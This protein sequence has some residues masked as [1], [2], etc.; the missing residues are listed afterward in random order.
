MEKKKSTVEGKRAKYGYMF[1]AP[2][3]IV[4]VVFSIY[5][6]LYTLYLSFTRFD[7]FVDPVWIGFDNYRRVLFD[8]PMFWKSLVNTIRI[9]GI[10]I[11]VQVGLAF[12]LIMV[13]SDLKYKIKG[14]RVFRILF[15]LPNLIAAASVAL[16]FRLMLNTDYGLLNTFLLKINLTSETIG[17]L[18]GTML[19]QLSVANIQTWMWFGNSFILFMAAVQAVNKE[20]IESSVIDGAGRIQMMRHV[21][22]PLIKPILIYVGVTSLIGGLQL[23]DVPYLITDGRGA[24]SDSLK[25]VIVYLFNQGFTYNN[26]GYASAIAFVLFIIVMIVSGAFVLIMKREEVRTFLKAR[27][28]RKAKL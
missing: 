23:F 3:L 19:A 13:F 16:I 11:V 4:F 12:I 1:V 27:K 20:V 18:D 26:F 10:N 7:A 14:L 2:M 15:Y 9:W 25:T 17:W 28:M 21:K 22:L 5:P 24:P 6:I 8:D